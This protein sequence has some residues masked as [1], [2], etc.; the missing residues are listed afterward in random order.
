MS[1]ERGTSHN[2]LPVSTA[3]RQSFSYFPPDAQR[4]PGPIHPKPSSTEANRLS[5]RLPGENGGLRQEGPKMVSDAAAEMWLRHEVIHSLF[6]SPS[7]PFLSVSLCMCVSVCFSLSPFSFTF[8]PSLL[9]P[10]SFLFLLPLFLLF[11]PSFPLLSLSLPPSLSFSL[12]LSLSHFLTLLFSPSFS[13]TLPP[14]PS[15][16]PPS[17]QRL[18]STRGS[19]VERFCVEL[20]GG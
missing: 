16:S 15:L 2:S 18:G 7:L 9:L 19:S 11:P 20:S 1:K 13:L 5:M 4:G 8:P 6:F 12:S 14:P 17:L 3:V 10:L